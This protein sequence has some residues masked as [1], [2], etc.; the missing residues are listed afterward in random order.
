MAGS[1]T[2]ELKVVLF[3]DTRKIDGKFNRLGKEASGAANSMDDLSS[4]AS[5]ATAAFA[6]FLG[7]AFNAAANVEDGIAAA[8]ETF[9]VYAADV[10][11]FAERAADAYGLS[12][13][14]T[15]RY[16][17]QYGN[18]LRNIG[19]KTEAEASRMSISLL[20]LAADMKS[21]NGGT[22]EQALGTI[23]SMLKGNYATMDNYGA[24][25]TAATVKAKA[26]E[27]GIHEG[28]AALNEQQKQIASLSLLWELTGRQQGD[29][30]RN[31]DGA[32]NSLASLQ[33]N[34]K[35]LVADIG[36]DVIPVG[37][38]LIDVLEL[39]M[40]GFGLIPGPVRQVTIGLLALGAAAKPTISG[41]SAVGTALDLL[42]DA[43]ARRAE[44]QLA[45]TAAAMIEARERGVELGEVMKR[46]VKGGIKDAASSL[47]AQF[48]PAVVAGTVAIGLA[49]YAY[50][51]WEESKERAKEASD[52]LTKAV[53]EEGDAL[54]GYQRNLESATGLSDKT[55]A[56]L[57]DIGVTIEE[58]AEATKT[59]SDAFERFAALVA[60]P[61]DRGWL[62][63]DIPFLT[64]ETSYEQQIELL[65]E[66]FGGTLPAA[67]R[68]SV[69]AFEAG[70]ITMNELQQIM[71][72]FDAI[73]DST[74]DSFKDMRTSAVNWLGTLDT[75]TEAQKKD[76]KERLDAAQNMEEYNSIVL[77][78]A[79][80]LGVNVHSQEILTE[81]NEDGTFVVEKL[82][83]ALE[84]NANVYSELIVIQ[85]G[86]IRRV[87]EIGDALASAND[88]QTQAV[89]VAKELE[90]AKRSLLKILEA[91]NDMWSDA[92]EESERYTN[93]ID[94]LTQVL[95]GKNDAALVAL[96]VEQELLSAE[97]EMLAVRDTQ[98]ALLDDI[99]E[100]EG[101][102]T[103]ARE[104]AADATEAQ[105]RVEREI[106]EDREAALQQVLD[107][108]RALVESQRTLADAK[109]NVFDIE[110][111]ILDL[112]QEAADRAEEARRDEIRATERVADIQAEI[113]D[114]RNAEDLETFNRELRE[115]NWDLI[116]AQK[117][118]KEA[119]E[120][121]GET[122]QEIAAM[123]RE[124]AQEL[125]DAEYALAE[126][127]REVAE[128]AENVAQVEVDA[129]E[130][131]AAAAAE[132][133]EAQDAIAAAV[134]A[135]GETQEQHA[136]RQAELELE[137]VAAVYAYAEAIAAAEAMMI[138]SGTPLDEMNARH[139][140]MRERFRELG[141]E[142]GFT[143]EK[144]GELTDSLL[145]TPQEF[146]RAWQMGLDQKA[147]DAAADA[148][149]ELTSDADKQAQETELAFAA[150]ADAIGRS[151]GELI[152]QGSSLEDVQQHRADLRQEM[153]DAA[154]QL[155]ATDQ[156]AQDY[157]DTLLSTPEEI[158]TVFLA[159]VDEL[160]AEE[161]EREL[162][163]IAAERTVFL[164]ALVDSG[165][166][167]KF[168]SAYNSASGYSQNGNTYANNSPV[169]NAAGWTAE[170]NPEVS[171]VVQGSV[172]SERELIDVVRDAVNEATRNGSRN[173]RT[174]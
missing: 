168:Q 1:I 12:T 55:R 106:A 97:R 172:V 121:I 87:Q 101:D 119:S 40:D 137:R 16:A 45:K 111:D 84:E 70:Q 143:E 95:G 22:M 37:N 85:D 83:D 140:A 28:S 29:F 3:G 58:V 64:G 89:S 27:L 93:L 105:G 15:L 94:N 100:A 122:E 114:V 21:F 147:I 148:I 36:D 134:T 62:G 155:G 20:G 125:A 90:D 117:E 81:K 26:L 51:K 156:E 6:A 35:N 167:S 71:N 157:I 174:R 112:R 61:P 66:S 42:G 139:A 162:D 56:N 59:G 47:K 5:V 131:R 160:A 107:S 151:S 146:T 135:L 46:D 77:E 54:V 60:M 124:T 161:A 32:A 144:V 23:G 11:N 91:E 82:S 165:T 163:R 130:E 173:G 170:R 123:R 18:M 68:K 164:Q 113:D 13:E 25:M 115:A 128:A 34:F 149:E 79:R 24:S 41:V 31:A 7:V 57:V 126:S 98:K 52:E 48:N 92:G 99:A 120:N 110:K 63:F 158:E 108:E 141:V 154:K 152:A 49:I 109:R 14:Q 75:L 10:E 142:A 96:E 2:E 78:L 129:A 136:S 50:N 169:T 17:N 69:D 171:V 43:K 73:A 103:E 9:G 159:N 102:I 65:E 150:W 86:Y 166:L 104:A 88:D 39:A 8:G 145:S 80:T 116:D 67:V 138:A 74:D 53:T 38:R 4:R 19:G 72:D 76:I 30:A 44:A 33:A 133:A 127:K 153:V 132:V 118:V